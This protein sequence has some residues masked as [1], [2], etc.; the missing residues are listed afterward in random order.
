MEPWWT[1]DGGSFADG[2]RVSVASHETTSVAVVEPSAGQIRFR[3]WDPEDPAT[4]E[5]LTAVMTTGRVEELVLTTF[6]H[7]T[8]AAWA[9]VSANGAVAL[10][11]VELLTGTTSEVSVEGLDALQVSSR[12]SLVMG[13]DQRIRIAIGSGQ[14]APRVWEEDGSA[15]ERLPSMPADGRLPVDLAYVDGALHLLT[16]AG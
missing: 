15:W 5:G 10:E 13:S 8:V 3:T 11:I 9:E 2:E 16:Q 6:G 4:A 14:G 1:R 7:R 12:W